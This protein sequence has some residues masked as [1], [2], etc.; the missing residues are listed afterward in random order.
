[1]GVKRARGLA[2]DA[3]VPMFARMYRHTQGRFTDIAI[4][5][6]VPRRWWEGWGIRITA[7]GMLYDVQGFGAVEFR[8]RSGER[9]RLGS[10]EPEAL[11][12]AGRAAIDWPGGGR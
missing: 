6:I 1:M 4:D 9:F 3:M 2:A 7:R 12:R 8:L 5:E 10:D 11:L